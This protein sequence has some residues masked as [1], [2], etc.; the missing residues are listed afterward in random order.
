M[1]YTNN[2]HLPQWVESDRILME[3][4]NDAFETIDTAMSATDERKKQVDFTDPYDFG[5][6]GIGVINV[7]QRIQLSF[8]KQYGLTIES[9]PD[10]G[11]RVRIRIPAL[12][13][14]AIKPYRKEESQ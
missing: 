6:S 13:E 14:V 1:N 9:E 4:F 12:D 8:G 10:E 3:D 5:G 11:T 2:Y 7:H